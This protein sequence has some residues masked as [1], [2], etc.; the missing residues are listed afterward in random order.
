M[1]LFRVQNTEIIGKNTLLLTIAPKRQRDA[2]RFQPGQ[3]AAIGFKRGGRPSPMRC[4]S[5]VSSP[6]HPEAVQFA[7]RIQGDFTTALSKLNRGDTVFLQGPFGDF[8]VNHEYD[9]NMF[10]LAGGIGVTPFISMARYAAETHSTVNMRLLYS[11]S[12]PYDIPFMNELIE[13]ER[14]NP[15]FK[16]A[17]F[18]SRGP[19]DSLQNVRRFAG[20]IDND[21]LQQLTDNEFNRYTYFVC[22]PKE[23]T[24]SLSSTLTANRVDEDRIVTEEF[25]PSS[26]IANA[27]TSPG[28]SISRWTYGLTGATLVLA[29]GFFMALDLDRV[30]PKYVNAQASAATQSQHAKQQTTTNTQT[31]SNDPTTTTTPSTTTPPPTTTT[32]AP[33]TTTPAPTTSTPTPTPT[34]AP[35]PTPTPTQSYQQPITSVS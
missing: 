30:V 22:G 21:R 23:F 33:V 16:V 20:R 10:M 3:Y 17:F 29:T 8:T 4:F 6:L 12:Y 19:I 9:Q 5:I 27:A 35:T 14:R 28:R 11:C 13:L 26:S 34:P 32:P 15:R 18:I 2:F 1:R 31:Q 7:M 24:K 25:T